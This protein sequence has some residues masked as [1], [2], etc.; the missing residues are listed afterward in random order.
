MRNPGPRDRYG[1]ARCRN[2]R[3]ALPRC[4]L[5][6]TL[7][8]TAATRSLPPWLLDVC[9]GV[10]CRAPPG[11]EGARDTGSIVPTV[12]SPQRRERRRNDLP[13]RH[14]WRSGRS[15]PT[16]HPAFGVHFRERARCLPRPGSGTSRIDLACTNGWGLPLRRGTAGRVFPVSHFPSHT[17]P[18]R[19]RQGRMRVDNRPAARSRDEVRARVPVRVW[20]PVGA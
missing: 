4:R 10:I 6:S 11:W 17:A 5:C 19:T 14:C 13:R 3:R 2:P 9:A 12:L 15:R 1:D 18:S 16:R 20:A 8:S 7:S